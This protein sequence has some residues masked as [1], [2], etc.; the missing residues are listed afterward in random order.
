MGNRFENDERAARAAACLVRRARST[1]AGRASGAPLRCA[2]RAAAVATRGGPSRGVQ[3]RAPGWRRPAASGRAAPLRGWVGDG[4]GGG[5]GGVPTGRQAPLRCHTR[6]GTDG[7]S[8]RAAGAR[9]RMALWAGGRAGQ[10]PGGARG[11]A[12]R[13]GGAGGVGRGPC[14][15]YP[16]ARG[17][18]AL[19]RL[20]PVA[21][22]A[23]APAGPAACGP[24]PRTLWEA[25][26]SRTAAPRRRA[27]TTPR[28]APARTYKTARRR[29]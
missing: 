13:G 8:E 5:E 1:G 24:A 12:A 2:L 11:G 9:G 16:S 22:H 15:G 20:R 21:R 7:P 6:P 19:A 10:G 23:C 29:K 27:A 25:L 18:I 28:A 3:W 26:R 4:V 17:P 14:S